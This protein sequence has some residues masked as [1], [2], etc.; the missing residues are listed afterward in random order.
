[1]CKLVRTI[2]ALLMQTI[3]FNV[4]L[5]SHCLRQQQIVQYNAKLNTHR[6]HNCES[7]FSLICED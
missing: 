4:I 3:R 1:M 5:K 7:C 2:D 6:L